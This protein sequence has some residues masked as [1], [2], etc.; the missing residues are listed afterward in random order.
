MKTSY[1]AASAAAALCAAS[2]ASAAVTFSGSSGSKAAS[3]SFDVVGSNLVVILTNTSTADVLVPV[4]VLTGV[5]FDVAGA[6]VNFSRISAVLNTGSTVTNGGT[7]EGA[8][9]VGGEWAALNSLS[10]GPG[11]RKYGISSSG[12]GLFGP[13]DRFTS[14]NLDGPASPDG[15]QYGITSA[16]DN[17]ATG[18][19]GVSTPLIKNSVK[20]TFGN[21]S[22]FD[23][24]RIGNVWF[25]YGTD[26]SEPGY[27]GNIPTPGSLALLGLAGV[28]VGRRRR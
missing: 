7:T 12:L 25:Q 16:G 9:G 26:L 2:V 24:G 19:A 5:F 1:V 4:D 20:F 27:E 10:G 28:V 17:A 23:L 13:G 11:N 15:L 14:T 3:V 6:T 21:A 22:G 18:N 8:N